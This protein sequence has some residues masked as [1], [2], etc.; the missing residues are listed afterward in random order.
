MSRKSSGGA[1][2]RQEP[3][4]VFG[5]LVHVDYVGQCAQLVNG[6]EGTAALYSGLGSDQKQ[7]CGAKNDKDVNAGVRNLQQDDE[8]ESVCGEGRI[9]QHPDHDRDNKA[10]STPTTTRSEF[11]VSRQRNFV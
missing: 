5:Q 7:N 6:L 8:I 10:I 3:V 1:L 11:A 2:S 9:C 4:R